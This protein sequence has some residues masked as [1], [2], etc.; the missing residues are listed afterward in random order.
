MQKFSNNQL[1]TNSLLQKAFALHQQGKLSDAKLLYQKILMKNPKHFNAIQ[2]LG[3]LYIQQGNF[4]KACPLFKKALSI[5]EKNASVF[6]NLGIALKN[7]NDLNN[8][9]E[10]YTKAIEIDPQYVDA[11]YNKACI[12]HQLNDFD[13]AIDFYDEVIFLNPL[14]IES[15]SNRGLTY[16]KKQNYLAAISSF[17]NALKIDPNCAEAWSNRGMALYEIKDFSG[18]LLSY[19]RAI[20]LKVDFK[21]AW[22]NRGV[23]LNE[24]KRFDEALESYNKALEL[25]LN[26]EE[27]WSNRGITLDHLKKHDIALDSVDKAIKLKPQ[28]GEAW[29]HR[30]N[31]LKELKRTD[32]ALDSYNKAIEIRPDY[33]EALFSRAVTLENL[34]QYDEALASYKKAITLDPGYTEAIFNRGVML[35]HNLQFTDGWV[36]YEARWHTKEFNSKPL[37]TSKSQWHGGKSEQRLFIWAEQGIGDQILYGSIFNELQ[38]FPNNKIISVDKKLIPVFQRSFPSY[39]FFDKTELLSEDLY[40]EQIPIGSLG[41]FFR[42]ELGDFKSTAYPYL[43]DDP[44]KTQSIKSSPPFSNQKTCG[45]SWRSANQ[46][47]GKDKSVSLEDLLPI[48]STDD[49]QFVNLQ[50][51]DTAEEVASLQEKHQQSLYSVPEIDIFND[52][53]GV[54]SIIS[55]CDLII[56]T[57]NSTAHLAGALGKETLLLTPYSVGKFWYW[58][59]IDGVSLWYPS[60]RVFPQTTQGE[61][62]DPINAIKAYLEK[63]DG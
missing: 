57:S 3:T 56:T 29:S 34:K 48:L 40:D 19:N 11:L 15:I 1:N 60:V 54:L 39:Q 53:D 50:Y 46:K 2:L 22:S 35:L 59:D 4:E 21:E 24:L 9:L 28:F 23:V 30:G 33:A 49:M 63:R 52:I 42:K 44:I 26:Y 31:I 41:Q 20:E 51:G 58:H 47:L 27:A 61:W 12:L 62:A 13:R 38:N 5:D 14:H 6:N 10:C 32:E 43:I 55:A 45:I 8:A 7:L 37:L 17:E 18:A 16:F 25:N 36:G